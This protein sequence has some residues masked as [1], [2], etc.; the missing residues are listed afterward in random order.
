MAK[1]GRPT[2]Y[3]T[4]IA[5]AICEEMAHTDHSL[6]R[7]CDAEG[8]PDPATVYRWLEAHEDFRDQYARARDRQADFMA[9]QTIDI[10]DDVSRDGGFSGSIAVARSR[11]RIDAR[12]WLA[13]KLAPKECGDKLAAEVNGPDGGPVNTSLT[14]RFI[15]PDD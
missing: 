11:V 3:N 14:V 12:K 1:T 10:A 5:H 2:S 13:S 8:M 9:S 7:I 15:D 6:R 4:E